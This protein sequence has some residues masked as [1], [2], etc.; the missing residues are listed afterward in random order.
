MLLISDVNLLRLV[1]ENKITH[2]DYLESSA[3]PGAGL[4][5][6]LLL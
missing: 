6:I 3:K 5:V 1:Y 2:A 4:A